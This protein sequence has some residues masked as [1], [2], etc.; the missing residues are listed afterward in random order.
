MNVFRL[1]D[2][3]QVDKIIAFDELPKSMLKGIKTKAFDG[4]PSFWK[5]WAKEN[6][7]IR[8]VSRLDSETGVRS[9]VEEPCTFMLDYKTTNEDKEKWQEITNYVRRAVDLSVRL[10]DKIEDMAVKLAK[11]PYSELSIEPENVPIIPIPAKAKVV[12]DV[13]ADVDVPAK[14][15]GRPKKVAVEV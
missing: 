8:V 2:G 14:R 13:D 11:D 9:E 15:P 12:V 3:G 4:F 6:S 10:M 7:S 5:R 1:I